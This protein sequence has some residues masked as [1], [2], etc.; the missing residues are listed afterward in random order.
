MACFFGPIAPQ[1]PPGIPRLTRGGLGVGRDGF[2]VEKEQ[3]YNARVDLSGESCGPPFGVP[4][5][6]LEVACFLGPSATR[7]PRR[8][9]FSR[10]DGD[11][12]PSK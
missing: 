1:D 2:H 12:R 3:S 6:L 9:V 4:R 11:L 7:V 8:D 5:V 10:S